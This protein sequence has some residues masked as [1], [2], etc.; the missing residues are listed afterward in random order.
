LGAK[1]DLAE[2]IGSKRLLLLL[3]NFEHLVEAAPGVAELLRACP[4]LDVLVTSRAPLHVAGEWEYAVDPLLEPEA[5]AL[6]GERA[7]AVTK[8]F[9]PSEEVGEICRSL[10]CLPLAIELAAAW[11]KVLSPSAILERLP[12]RLR[13]LIGGA[14]DLPERQRTLRATIAW[15]YDLLSEDEQRLFVRL[16]VFS[17]GCTLEAAEQICGAGLDVLASLVDKSLVRRTGDRF[18]MLETIRKFATERLEPQGENEKLRHR[19]AAWYR[20]LVENAEPALEARV[21]DETWLKRLAAEHNNVGAALSWLQLRGD[22][23]A[24]GRMVVPLSLFW[25]WGGHLAEGEGWLARVLANMEMVD[26]ALRSRVLLR[27][28]GLA[29][30][31]GEADRGRSYA[32]ASLA[33]C[34]TAGDWSG[35][36]WAH[37]GIG[38]AVAAGRKDVERAIASLEEARTLALEHGLRELVGAS[39]VTLGDLKLQQGC[40]DEARQLN[41]EARGLFR[42]LGSVG[43]EVLAQ[44]NLGY[45]A[46]HAGRIEEAAALYR[47]SLET[48][49]RRADLLRA[50]SCLV[51]AAWVLAKQAKHEP[52]GRVLG[53]GMALFEATGARAE[54]WMDS[55]IRDAVRATLADH[56]GEDALEALVSEGRSISFEDAVSLALESID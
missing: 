44:I 4:R 3:D 43:G 9:V 38:A 19:H 39:T 8:D 11:T 56:L 30:W 45:A 10:D 28:G 18:W 6:F 2:H 33:L 49:S 1:R 47:E 34:Q 13:L 51:G 14:R 54:G 53:A 55:A 29:T 7:R 15:S 52:A 21:G 35:I 17:G 12:Q 31:R 40:F 48:C 5:V 24:L 41:E 23:E 27:A 36:A 50:S 42:E 46:A 22:Y 32:E 16:A 20:E 25:F 37:F 26:I